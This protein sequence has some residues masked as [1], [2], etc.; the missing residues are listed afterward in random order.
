[1]MPKLL[2]AHST[3]GVNFIAKDEEW[4]LGE[5]F[6]GEEGVQFGFRLSEALKVSAV[7]NEDD[8]IGFGEVIAPEA[9][10]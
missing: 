2:F 3:R 6:D 7:N 8:P 4:N 10:G 1:M 5:S 9:A